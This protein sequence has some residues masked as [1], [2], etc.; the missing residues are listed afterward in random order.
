MFIN[1]FNKTLRALD[2]FKEQSKLQRPII[3]EL[4][5]L[6]VADGFTPPMIGEQQA[7]ALYKILEYIKHLKGI[8]QESDMNNAEKK[9]HTKRLYIPLTNHSIKEDSK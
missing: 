3:K 1:P 2:L 6:M 9:A 8:G 4:N 5:D 7:G